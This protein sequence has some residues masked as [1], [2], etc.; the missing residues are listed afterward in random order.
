MKIAVLGAGSYVSR[1]TLPYLLRAPD[2]E[3]ILY[4]RTPAQLMRWVVARGV[5]EDR[6]SVEST[7]E[8]GRRNFDT[9]VNFIGAGDPRLVNQMGDSILALTADWDQRVLHELGKRP[10]A[11]Y[12]FASSGVATG[13]DFRTPRKAGALLR[14]PAVTDH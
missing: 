10:S 1:A 7:E 9:I 11:K 3:A 13:E 12:I 6:I 5:P 14:T 4:T 8:F 2:F